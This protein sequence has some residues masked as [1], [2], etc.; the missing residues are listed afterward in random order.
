MAKLK[1]DLF[2]GTFA[3]REQARSVFK[4]IQKSGP[5]TRPMLLDRLA[6]PATTLSRVLDRLTADGLITES[7]QADSTG[8]RPATLFSVNANARQV[9]GI[10]VREAQCHL[11]LMDLLGQVIERSAI[12]LA[13]DSDSDEWL[14]SLAGAAA[15]LSGMAPGGPAGVAGAGLVLP[16]SLNRSIGKALVDRIG[17][18]LDRPSAMADDYSGLTAMNHALQAAADPETILWIGDRV[19]LVLPESFLKSGTDS[20]RSSIE[21]LLLSDP[22]T[23]DS[24]KLAT[25]ESLVTCPAIGQRFAAMRDQSSLGFP[26]FMAALQIGKKKALRL[27]DATAEALAQ[28]LINIACVTG[29]RQCQLSGALIESW[30]AI[31]DLIKDKVN[32][33]GARSGTPIR[34]NRLEPAEWDLAVSAAAWMLSQWLDRPAHDR[35]ARPDLPT[36]R[37]RQLEDTDA[38]VV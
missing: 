34:V 26:D 22:L 19:R 9:I 8:G 2:S 33:M 3:V 10:A 6:L 38:E 35:S 5:M 7:G 30:P 27:M 14:E 15:E 18:R 32:R 11:V 24:G 1:Y 4:L 28:T 21:G 23:E 17:A 20:D 12:N 16:D 29:T 31:V 37:L 25:L 36:G 13:V